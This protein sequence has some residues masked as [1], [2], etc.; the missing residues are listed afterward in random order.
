MPANAGRSDCAT[1]PTVTPSVPANGRSSSTLISGFWPF[2]DRP[3]STAPGVAR[4]MSASFG[5]RRLS[6]SMSGPRSWT[7]ISFRLPKVSLLIHAL[8][9]PIRA[10]S[11]RNSCATTSWCFARSCLGTRRTYTF[12]SSTA[13]DA[14]PRPP[15]PP[16]VAYV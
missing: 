15:D 14:L 1:W 16:M 8:T 11:R 5:A 13:P 2:V 6:S 10:R 3:T 4:S 12:A 7:W 9:P